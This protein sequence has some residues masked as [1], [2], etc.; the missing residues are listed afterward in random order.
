VL[1]QLSSDVESVIVT[2]AKSLVDQVVVVNAEIELIGVASTDHSKRG[3]LFAYDIY[4]K[5]IEEV[6]ISPA[7]INVDLDI[8]LDEETK[9]VG[10]IPD[11][12]RISLQDGYFIKGVSVDPP[13]ALIR[14]KHSILEGIEYL[15]TI[16]LTINDLSKDY[17]TELDIELPSDI[18]IISPKNNRVTLN[19]ELESLTYKREIEPVINTKNL[20]AMYN[21]I[22][23]T[24]ITLTII[25]EPNILDSIEKNDIVFD[26]DFSD[27]NKLGTYRVDVSKSD[28]IYPQGV[29]L[30]DYTPK[31]WE[32]NIVYK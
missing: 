11:L 30:E 22:Y 23:D 26:L 16:R 15:P 6:D 18:S 31:L 9:T 14:G 3:Y 17:A 27:M 21:V 8:G 25:G 1:N 19:I 5:K 12:D 28:F 32:I 2:G 13:V 7:S 4:G 29:S 10:I 24:P 20:S